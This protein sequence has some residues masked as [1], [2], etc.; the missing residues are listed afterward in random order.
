MVSHV[1]SRFQWSRL[2]R[3]KQKWHAPFLTANVASAK[4]L[5]SQLAPSA[6]PQ[7]DG[8]R[9]AHELIPSPDLATDLIDYVALPDGRMA[10]LLLD[11]PGTRA[12]TRL[13]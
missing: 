6:P 9:V 3:R 7:L 11:V 8:Y 13:P 2:Q 5:R 10:C 1:I 4:R 12:L